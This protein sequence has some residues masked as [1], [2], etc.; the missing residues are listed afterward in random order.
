MEY[1]TR[2]L[3]FCKTAQKIKTIIL[4]LRDKIMEYQIQESCKD[5]HINNIARS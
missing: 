4:N 2:L 3:S 1:N 5:I